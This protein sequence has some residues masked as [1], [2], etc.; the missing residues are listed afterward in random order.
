MRCIVKNY[1]QVK[2]NKMV[3][4]KEYKIICKGC[5]TEFKWK[6]KNKVFCDSCMMERKKI[7]TKLYKEKQK[8]MLESGFISNMVSII[9]SRYSAYLKGANRRK[10]DFNISINDFM[11]FWQKPCEYCGDEIKTIGIDR[12]N[13]NKGY[14]IDNICSCCKT[15]NFLKGSLDKHI[16]IDKCKKITMFC[17]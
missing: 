6:R 13:N 12:V 2:V 10:Y 7:K 4:E 3:I 8:T 16:F 5:E 11:L 15:C 1:N 17:D 14:T 9:N